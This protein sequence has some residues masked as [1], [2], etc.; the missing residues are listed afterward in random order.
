MAI[1]KQTL[2]H[3]E[4]PHPSFN[5]TSTVLSKPIIITEKN[6]ILAYQFLI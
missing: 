5:F 1:K 6:I 2:R 4:Y 3:T